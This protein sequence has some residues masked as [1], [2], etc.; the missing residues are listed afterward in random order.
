M[1]SPESTQEADD[2]LLD[3]NRESTAMRTAAAVGVDAI[4]AR[5][6]WVICWCQPFF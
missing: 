1:L 5:R 2:Q 4:D 3:G 6:A